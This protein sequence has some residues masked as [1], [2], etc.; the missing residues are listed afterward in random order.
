MS[1]W[2]S[3]SLCCFC[4]LC[5]G[6]GA[7]DRELEAS[8]QLFHLHQPYQLSWGMMK[9]PSLLKAVSHLRKNHHVQKNRRLSCPES[10]WD[11]RYYWMVAQ[12]T[13]SRMD[14]LQSVNITSWT[15]DQS[16]AL[17]NDLYTRTKPI[18]YELMSRDGFGHE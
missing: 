9:R 18:L 7:R 14:P 10:Q 6:G 1:L 4:G 5:F 2:V 17:I 3:F 15:Q 8:N 11:P 12:S 13:R 16:S